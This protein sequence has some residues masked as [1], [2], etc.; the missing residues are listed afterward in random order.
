MGVNGP[1]Q[2]CTSC[3]EKNTCVP[4]LEIKSSQ[5]RLTHVKISGGTSL[6]FSAQDA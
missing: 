3:Y 6:A 1:R 2:K 5:D 4:I